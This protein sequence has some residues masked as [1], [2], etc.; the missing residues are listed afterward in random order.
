MVTQALL[1]EL[2][3][4]LLE[5]QD[6]TRGVMLGLL[7]RKHVFLLGPPGT[8]KSM[9]VDAVCARIPDAKRFKLLMT[10]YTVPDEVVGP[11]SIPALEAERYKR[12]T[13]GYLPEAD[14][15]FLD[16]IFKANSAILNALLG[17]LNEREYRNDG[18]THKAP[19]ITC[20]GASNELPQGEDLSALYDRFLLRYYVPYIVEEKSFMTLLTM[21][22]TPPTVKLTLAELRAAQQAADAVKLDSGIVDAIVELRARLGAEG[23]TASDRTWRA[24]VSVLRA[25]A[26]L[27]GRSAVTRSD[28]SILANVLWNDPAERS[29]VAQKVVSF[30]QPNVA[31]A[32]EMLDIATELHKVIVT[33]V[34]E[35]RDGSFYE[36]QAKFR[37]LQEQFAA[38]MSTD[39]DPKVREVATRLDSMRRSANKALL[40]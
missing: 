13:A 5:R 24:S 28:L 18:A 22:E 16:E 25:E 38:S 14:I 30:A 3:S 37:K 7:A 11:L 29:K 40:V 34:T 31:K 19:L 17:L 36:T 35:K 39:T 23:I 8:A 1:A 2:N 15:V 20:I 12:V 33:T 27:S 21:V 6:V 4:V 26:F 9:T 32:L 10:R